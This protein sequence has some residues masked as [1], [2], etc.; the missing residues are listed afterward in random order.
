VPPRRL[1]GEVLGKGL[2]PVIGSAH[3]WIVVPLK[4]LFGRSAQVDPPDPLISTEIPELA[5]PIECALQIVDF[6][7]GLGLTI[8]N[9][10]M[11]RVPATRAFVPEGL[12]GADSLAG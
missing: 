8:L 1:V 7:Q 12:E 3:L 5:D 4:P 2:E 6:V 9:R 10:Q 11:G